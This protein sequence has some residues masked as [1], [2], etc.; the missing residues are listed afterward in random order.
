MAVCFL[1]RTS[2]AQ[3]RPRYYRVEIS[4]N[5][6]GEWWVMINRGLRGRTDR[7]RIVLFAELRAASLA[8]DQARER[9]LRVGYQ[10]S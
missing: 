2:S 10:R 4:L 6:F 3:C 1:T 9:M 8:A 7:Q 5:L